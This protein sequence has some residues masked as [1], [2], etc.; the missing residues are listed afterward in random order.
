MN[1]H[2]VETTKWSEIKVKYNEITWAPDLGLKTIDNYV[3]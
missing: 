2:E 3:K 1:L